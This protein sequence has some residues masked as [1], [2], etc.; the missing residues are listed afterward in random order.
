MLRYLAIALQIVLIALIVVVL[1]L[2]AI[3]L[4]TAGLLLIGQ[5]VGGIFG[6]GILEAAALALGSSIAL[7]VLALRLLAPGGGEIR[8]SEGLVP[9]GSDE[10]E[11]PEYDEV[12]DA[13]CPNCEQRLDLPPRPRAERRR[14]P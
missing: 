1:V 14:R 9:P 4:A 10:P 7:V 6:V 11:A 5:M 13:Y 2:M 3:G 8:Y 12:G